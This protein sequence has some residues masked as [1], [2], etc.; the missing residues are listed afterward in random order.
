M[1][2]LCCA[3]SSYEHRCT[4]PPRRTDTAT[5]ASGGKQHLRIEVSTT[6]PKPDV[7]LD[8]A[9]FPPLCVCQAE[10][11]PLERATVPPPTVSAS[12]ERQSPDLE[13]N[14]NILDPKVLSVSP[15]NDPR[16]VSCGF[17]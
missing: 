1:T 10:Q 4:V 13:R 17:T 15:A 7:R 12:A 2:P 14:W 6:Q 3:P 5:I 11:I 8:S 16:Q 9:P